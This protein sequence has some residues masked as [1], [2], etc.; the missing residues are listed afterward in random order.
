MSGLYLDLA[1][2]DSVVLENGMTITLEH[3]SGRRARLRLN[4][5]T[6]AQLKRSAASA[7]KAP[8]T[9]QLELVH[10]PAA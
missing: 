3:K 6:A 5:D 10:E 9:E 7:A 4:G 1:P 2:G 8:L